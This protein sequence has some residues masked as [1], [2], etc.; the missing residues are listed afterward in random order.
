MVA[1][2]LGVDI[3][4]ELDRARVAAVKA[5]SAH[6]IADGAGG[7]MVLAMHIVRDGAARVTKRVPGVVERK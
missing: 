7:V 3:G 1:G 4:R 2:Q 6:R 5:E